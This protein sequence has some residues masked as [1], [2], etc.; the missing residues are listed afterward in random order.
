MPTGSPRA[1]WTRSRRWTPIPRCWE[2]I[3][4]NLVTDALEHS[5]AP[6]AVPVAAA[7]V[8]A[9]AEPPAEPPGVLVSASRFADRVELRVAD[10]GPS[11]REAE[12]DALFD[13][14]LPAFDAVVPPA[15]TRAGPTLH[16]ALA[17][18]FAEAMGSGLTCEDTPGGGLTMVLDLPVWHPAA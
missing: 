13:P 10:H 16:L 18:G 5:A 11:L 6:A 3:L 1:G 9:A 2:R 12:R 8:S 17:R 7:A 14:A 4:S 15:A